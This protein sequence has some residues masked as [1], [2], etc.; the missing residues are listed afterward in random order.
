MAKDNILQKIIKA[1]KVKAEMKKG[2]HEWY[3]LRPVLGC[4]N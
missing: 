3:N 2:G 1:K 4:A